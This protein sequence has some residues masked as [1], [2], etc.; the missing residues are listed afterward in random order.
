RD[1]NQLI[2]NALFIFL[3]L[4]VD[5]VENLLRLR[6]QLCL[7]HLIPSRIPLRAVRTISLSESP[8]CLPTDVSKTT[9]SSS[10]MAPA[11][12]ASPM[13][14]ELQNSAWW[15]GPT[16]ASARTGSCA[17]S[18]AEDGRR[19]RAVKHRDTGGGGGQE[20]CRSNPAR[21]RRRCR[22]RPRACRP[23]TR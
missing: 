21:W 10:L 19:P 5:I 17:G 15:P 22:A 8:T 6:R 1:L 16:L 18:R 9:A 23:A 4:L 11:R 2:R 14:R 3:L 7:H 13:R 12:T 20:R